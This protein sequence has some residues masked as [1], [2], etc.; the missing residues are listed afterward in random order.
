MI[1]YTIDSSAMA[2]NCC[3]NHI[4]HYYP[5]AVSLALLVIA[6]GKIVW[7]A[8][9][10]AQRRDILDVRYED[11]AYADTW[12]LPKL[13]SMLLTSRMEQMSAYTY[14]KSTATHKR[15]PYHTKNTFQS[16]NL[17]ILNFN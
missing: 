16:K 11:R 7:A 4:S 8:E 13:R 9:A 12:S 10:W 15:I 5:S 14:T 2:S 1:F 6:G 3:L 17:S